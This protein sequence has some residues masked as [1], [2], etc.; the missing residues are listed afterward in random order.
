M[1]KYGRGGGGL[2]QKNQ[3]GE[4]NRG[5]PRL[6]PPRPGSLPLPRRDHVSSNDV[7]HDPR[8]KGVAARIRG[9]PALPFELVQ[10]AVQRFPRE[11]HPAADL[12]DPHSLPPP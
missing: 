4:G 5:V 11:P 9:Q 8:E 2:M 7:S 10:R 12:A 1:P 6:S 3:G